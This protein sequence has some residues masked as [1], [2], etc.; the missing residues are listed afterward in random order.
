MATIFYVAFVRYITLVTPTLIDRPRA[1]I[2]GPTRRETAEELWTKS[3]MI[4]GIEAPPRAP[5]QSH[6]CARMA[7]SNASAC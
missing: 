2:F 3:A 7:S 1:A 6:A 4:K 5:H